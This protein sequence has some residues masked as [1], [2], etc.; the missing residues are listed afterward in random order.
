MKKWWWREVYQRGISLSLSL[1]LYLYIYFFGVLWCKTSSISRKRQQS[2]PIFMKLGTIVQES[3]LLLS[4]GYTYFAYTCPKFKRAKEMTKKNSTKKSCWTA[5][6]KGQVLNSHFL[7]PGGYCSH[8]VGHRNL[9]VLKML[10]EK[11]KNC[12]TLQLGCWFRTF[13]KG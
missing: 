6:L 11:N 9:G 1:S 7:F 3:L 12:T 5:P 13:P 8:L 2:C 4:K 10:I